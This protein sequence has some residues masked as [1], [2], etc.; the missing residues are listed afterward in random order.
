MKRFDFVLVKEIK[1]VFN[2]YVVVT[3]AAK[4]NKIENLKTNLLG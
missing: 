4:K 2:K 1:V 3:K